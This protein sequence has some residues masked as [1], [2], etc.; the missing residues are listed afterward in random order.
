M[1]DSVVQHF[2]QLHSICNR[3]SSEALT[4][5]T[6]NGMLQEYQS[7]PKAAFCGTCIHDDTNR[8]FDQHVVE[9]IILFALSA[10]PWSNETFQDS[11]TLRDIKHGQHLHTYVLR[12][13]CPSLQEDIAFRNIYD[14]LDHVDHHHQDFFEIWSHF[15]TKQHHVRH[16]E[17]VQHSASS[18][19]ASVQKQ[20]HSSQIF[21][22]L[23]CVSAI[24]IEH[25]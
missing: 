5:A 2:V 20:A 25:H 15:N 1:T 18:H 17:G 8:D 11:F 19:S 10:I 13:K 21:M 22:D 7:S 24:Q 4:L 3:H 14:M 9:F 23:M 6:M 12:H 16:H